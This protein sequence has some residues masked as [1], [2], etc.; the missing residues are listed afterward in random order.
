MAQA[1]WGPLDP[2]GR[3]GADLNST[4]RFLFSC[5]VFNPSSRPFA[6]TFLFRRHLRPG[7]AA[8]CLSLWP[9]HSSLQEREC[10]RVL[11]TKQ[12]KSWQAGTLED[13]ICA[14]S[15]LQT[16]LLSQRHSAEQAV[17]SC[18]RNGAAAHAQNG[19]MPD[20]WRQLAESSPRTLLARHSACLLCDRTNASQSF[21]PNALSS[22][23][24][25]YRLSL[26]L[27]S[28]Q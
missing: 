20:L 8:L 27:R 10:W 12:T 5:L 15:T 3:A 21:C 6:A 28:V 4:D 23:A 1:S 24:R 11:Q 7:S 2:L 16:V 14:E 26:Y 9:F 22:R 25:S 19:Q 13:T 17:P 18:A